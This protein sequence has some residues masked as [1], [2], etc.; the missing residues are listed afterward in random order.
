MANRMISD[1][2]LF[3]LSIGAEAAD[4]LFDWPEQSWKQL[5]SL[6]VLSSSIP[7]SFGGNPLHYAELLQQS[8][9]LG[10]H[11]LTT[12]FILSQR[13]A[14]VRRILVGPA[15]LQKQF[16][17]GLA[18]G[19]LFVTVGMSQLTTSRQ[20]QKPSLHVELLLEGD[21]QLDGEVP[22]VTAAD[23]A[24]AIVIGGTLDDGRQVLFLIPRGWP[25]LT[26]DPPMNLIVLRGSRTTTMRCDRLRIGSEWLLNGPA[27][28]VLGKVGGGGL[29]TSMLALGLTSAVVDYLRKEAVN[30]SEVEPI[31][32]EVLSEYQRIRSG[33]TSILDRQSDDPSETLTIRA[34]ST[35]LVIRTTQIALTLAKG[36]GLIHPHPVQRWVRQANFFLVWSCPRIVSDAVLTAFRFGSGEEILR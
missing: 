10:K 7:E 36:A 6:G 27:E 4:Q 22:W 13:E 29:E 26:I 18:S 16:L 33:I 34:R 3:P 24:D 8:E 31:L 15:H 21:Y 19:E 11:C 1:E 30:R 17:P 5:T 28:F 14:G 20:H 2:D 32:G 9:L 25:G 35:V 23:H 12:S